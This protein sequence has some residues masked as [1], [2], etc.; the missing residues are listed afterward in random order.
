MIDTCVLYSSLS[1]D[2]LLQMAE[3]ELYRPIWPELI[4]EE[5]SRNLQQKANLAQE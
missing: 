4:I 2:L 5:L 1:R 3:Q